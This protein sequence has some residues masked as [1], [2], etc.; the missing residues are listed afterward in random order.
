MT[1]HMLAISTPSA[2]WH[3]RLN[4]LHW[5]WYNR[6]CQKRRIACQSL[7]A[8]WLVR[9]CQNPLHT[10]SLSA[11]LALRGEAGTADAG[12]CRM[13]VVLLLGT[14]V[15]RGF[16]RIGARR[17]ISS[18]NLAAIARIVSFQHRVKRILGSPASLDQH[19]SLSK[20][21]IG[22]P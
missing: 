7:L 19:R 10:Y 12:R 3:Q 18:C 14:M 5:P 17:R 22:P 1:A 13:A 6:L 2:H 21:G 9:P 20:E 16:A 11:S 4:P 15:E 8:T